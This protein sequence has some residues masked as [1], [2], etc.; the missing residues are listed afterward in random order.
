MDW[1]QLTP[2]YFL[3]FSFII[4]KLHSLKTK[5]KRNLIKADTRSNPLHL[6]V[7]AFNPWFTR[8]AC[9][10]SVILKKIVHSYFVC[11]VSC[12]KQVPRLFQSYSLVMCSVTKSSVNKNITNRGLSFDPGDT[13]KCFR[14]EEN[15]IC[16]VAR[17]IP[18]DEYK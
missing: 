17:V 14:L 5:F 12:P 18:V 13:G 1:T 4:S 3:K 7:T 9:V 15:H 16:L 8:C 10:L 2:H 11:T 6:M